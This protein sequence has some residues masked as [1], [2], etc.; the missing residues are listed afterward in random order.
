MVHLTNNVSY[1]LM[2][3]LAVLIFPAMLI[4]RGAPVL[5]LL[6]TDL[7][8]F[9]AA[10]VSVVTFYMVSQ[11]AAGL[12]WRRQIRYLPA[13]LGVGIGLSVNNARAVLS[14]LFRRGGTFH[15][16]PKYRIEHRGEDWLGKRY[17]P[18]RN[19]SM[20][21]ELAL[22]LYF[23][24]CLAYAVK[25]RMWASLPFLYLFVQGYLYMAVLAVAPLV[26]RK[27]T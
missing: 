1:A 14:G 8:L 16:T 25:E 12:D 20:L 11:K 21:V 24:G 5:N 3:V 18:G 9:L 10:T 7:P 15:R 19:L 2:V 26:R 13:V 27:R 17:R 4:R 23:A 22:A 6:L